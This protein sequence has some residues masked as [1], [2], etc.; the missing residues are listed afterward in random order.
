MLYVT[1]GLVRTSII[2]VTTRLSRPPRSGWDAPFSGD[3]MVTPASASAQARDNCFYCFDNCFS[4]QQPSVLCCPVK[5]AA[6]LQLI[7]N[8]SLQIKKNKSG[9]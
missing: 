2:H 7:N 4:P 6:T 3:P 8:R 9:V 1:D 5:N